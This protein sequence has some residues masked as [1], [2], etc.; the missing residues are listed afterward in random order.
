MLVLPTPQSHK[1][2]PDEWDRLETEA[3]N[4]IVGLYGKTW[5]F[6]QVDRGHDLPL[7]FPRL[8]GSLTD[9]DQLDVK[10]AMKERDRQ[11]GVDVGAKQELRKGIQPPG[12]VGNADSWWRGI[13]PGPSSGRVDL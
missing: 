6:W 7:G 4:E 3:M 13:Q 2:K 1:D 5:H 9:A 10:E 12:V 8:M 11:H